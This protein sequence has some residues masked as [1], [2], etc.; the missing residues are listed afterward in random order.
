MEMKNLKDEEYNHDEKYTT[1][2]YKKSE[3][4]ATRANQGADLLGFQATVDQGDEF[5]AKG[6]R[7]GRG[8]R[9]QRP[10]RQ[11]GGARRRRGG[12][13]VVDDNDFPTL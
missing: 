6:K 11:E 9:D 13:I 12:K 3:T 1:K 4:K 10:E 8:G 2:I 5:N 7:G